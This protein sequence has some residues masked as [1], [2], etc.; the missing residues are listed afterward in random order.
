MITRIYIDNYRCF[1]NFEFQPARINL[2]L[3]ANGSGKSALFEVLT[4]VLDLVVQSENIEDSFPADSRTRWDQ[5]SRQRVELQVLIADHHYDYVLVVDH[6]LEN[7]RTLI[8]NERLTSEGKTLFAYEGGEVHLHNNEGVKGVSFPFRGSK[9]F[10]AQ[11]ER[12]PATRDLMIW[13]DFMSAVWMLGLNAHV[14]SA[15]SQSEHPT[16]ARDGANFA[17][18]YRH[19]SAE[20][21]ERLQPLWN[22]LEEVLPGFRSLKLSSAD[23]KGRTRELAAQMTLD[24]TLYQLFFDELSDGQRALIILYTILEARA[25]EGCMLL[26]EPELHVGLTEIQPWLVELDS[27]LEAQGQVFIASH[28]PEVVDYLAAGDSF[29]FE[30]P[31]GGPAR[32]RRANFERESGLSASAQ[33][34]RGLEDVG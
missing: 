14:V 15:T 30:R 28:N 34:A 13:K 8:E 12:R 22:A 2:L 1:T 25:G 29:V 4:G 31:D 7:N 3:G 26:D 20:Y 32:V 27:R 5:R 10:L 21:P 6:D 19:F 11:I 9:S 18:W 17:S 23:A 16:L 24:A 33:L